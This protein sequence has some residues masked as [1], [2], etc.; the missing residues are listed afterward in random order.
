MQHNS[1]WA[2][3]DGRPIVLRPISVM[4]LVHNIQFHLPEFKHGGI[5]FQFMVFLALQ[6]WFFIDFGAIQI[7]YL[8]TY[9]LCLLTYHFPNSTN[10]LTFPATC[11]N[12]T[13]P[14]ATVGHQWIKPSHQVTVFET[15]RTPCMPFWSKW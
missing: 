8:L 13:K 4:S 7:M 11:R 9:L 3:C 14:F 15:I 12:N 5:L 6:T 2:A 1:Q 10:S